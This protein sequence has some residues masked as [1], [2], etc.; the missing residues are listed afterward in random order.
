[1]STARSGNSCRRRE[2]PDRYARRPMMDRLRAWL[3]R[4]GAI[5][6]LLV[7][8]F[9]V[10]LGFGGL[11][12]VLPIYF[13]EQ[14]IDLATLGLVIAAWPAA[15]LLSE[16]LFGWLADRTARVPLMVIGLVAT[17]VF[18]ALPL[19]LDRPGRVPPAAGRSR[20]GRGD[21]RPGR[22]RL[23]DRRDATRATRR[24]VRAVRR[25]A[26]GRAAARPV[27]RGVRR[28][29]VRR[30]RVRVRVQRH[31]RDRRR[32]RHRPARPRRGSRPQGRRIAL[33][34]SHDDAARL[35]VRRGSRRGRPG[36]RSG[37]RRW[38]RRRRRHGRCVSS[39]G[40]SSRRSSSTSA[41]T[42]AAA[43]TRSSGACSCRVWAPTS[44]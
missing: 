16:P 10:W 6:P 44:R 23:P 5:L 12:P 32:C 25:R 4:W 28:R 7:A 18:G 14:G 1:M 15:R 31:R 30:H 39:T 13:D 37:G 29:P 40:A 27:D 2:P 42:T 35:A 11:L 17:G 3:D 9:V 19:V 26:D 8:E 38:T 41:A 21:L 22:P 36:G 43:R 24:G 34:G 20:A 33:V